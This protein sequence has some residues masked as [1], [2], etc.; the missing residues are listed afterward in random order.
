MV[1]W[2]VMGVFQDGGVISQHLED[3]E[4]RDSQVDLAVAIESGFSGGH[5]TIAEGSTGV[6]KS[7]S[8]LVPAIRAVLDGKEKNV[9]TDCK[10]DACEDSSGAEEERRKKRPRAVVATA[11]IALQE[12]LVNK[13]LPFLETVFSANSDEPAIRYALVKGRNN[14]FC[15]DAWRRFALKKSEGAVK[16]GENVTTVDTA[17]ILPLCS[18]Y[19]REIVRWSGETKTGDK[20][21]LP[22][23]PSSFVWS[24][25]SRTAAECLG[26]DC[27][28]SGKCFANRARAALQDMDV[29][30]VNYHLLFAAVEVRRKTGKE[31]VLPP[32]QYLIL[33]EAHKAADIARSFF[34]WQI[35]EGGLNRLSTIVLRALRVVDR[36]LNKDEVDRISALVGE[37]KKATTGFWHDL[38]EKYGK[39]LGV[40]AIKKQGMLNVDVFVELLPE[41]SLVLGDMAELDGWSKEDLAGLRK[42]RDRSAEL[43]G[44]FRDIAELDRSNAVYCLDRGGVKKTIRVVKK[45]LNVGPL[46]WDQM[47]CKTKSTVLTSATLAVDGDFSYLCKEVGLKKSHGIIA[48]SPFD[49][50][51]Q[52]LLI[53]SERA[54]NPKEEG[55]QERVAKIMSVVIKEAGGRTLGLFTSYRVLKYV[56]DYLRRELPEFKFLV[57]GDAP[58]MTLVKEFKEDIPSVLLGTD[59]FWTGVDVPGEACSCV[60]I[61][62]IPFPHPGDP[63]LEA[64]GE[65]CG[66]RGFWEVSVPR[67]V[68]QLRQGVGRLIRRRT[69]R[70]VVI[71]LDNRLITKGYGDIFADSL[72]PFS[73]VGSLRGSVVEKWLSDGMDVGNSDDEY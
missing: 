11:N 22:F 1:G 12:Q 69:D 34:G 47:F 51:K 52:G 36:R 62:K 46:L 26:Q 61:D 31:L 15:W 17:R 71:I 50:R 73:R 56:S 20:S 64:L 65:K 33:D 59:S 29:L 72:P 8:Y 37:L 53:L 19:E 38:D 32:F 70:G 44:Q 41:V 35:V 6:G 21:D 68:L 23:V 45:M 54:P 10:S 63:V 48:D 66:G 13:D 25:F 7:L 39:S 55:Y 16:F 30:I 58:R 5:H 43:V 57:Q 67:A 60:I 14:Y 2:N 49:F 4:V 18:T 3:Y 40:L 24:Q 42:A 28:S 27:A 9:V